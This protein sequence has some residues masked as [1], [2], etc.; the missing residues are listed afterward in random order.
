M[1]DLEKAAKAHDNFTVSINLVIKLKCS[2]RHWR[3]RL[4]RIQKCSDA[5]VEQ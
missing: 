3:G 4:C 5:N 2:N 1:Y